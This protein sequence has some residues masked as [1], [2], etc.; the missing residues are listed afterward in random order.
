MISRY[1]KGDYSQ[2]GDLQPM[3]IKNTKTGIRGPKAK[4]LTFQNVLCER[5][6][7][8]RSQPWDNSYA[9][10]SNCLRSK[11]SSLLTEKKLDFRSIYGI[12]WESETKN[13]FKYFIKLFGSYIATGK[14]EVSKKITEFLLDKTNHLNHIKFKFYIKPDIIHLQEYYNNDYSHLFFGEVKWLGKSKSE[15]ESLTGWFTNSGISI[16]WVYNLSIDQELHYKPFEIKQ[17]ENL[18]IL[19]AESL[20]KKINNIKGLVEFIENYSTDKIELT[21]EILNE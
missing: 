11:S 2:K 9:I 1:G 13:L 12:D 18:T 14:I 16:Y 8:E 6:N 4:I 5:C 17:I 19:M 20:P 3:H 15:I 7:N 21:N 10:F